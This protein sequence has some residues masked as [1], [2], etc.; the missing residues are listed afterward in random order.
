[1]L[2]LI[3]G[4]T[5]HQIALDLVWRHGFVRAIDS[6]VAVIL[7]CFPAPRDTANLPLS[8]QSQNQEVFPTVSETMLEQTNKELS[9]MTDRCLFVRTHVELVQPVS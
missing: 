1:M 9:V 2:T 8:A 5:P 7:G 3:Q 6:C 4:N